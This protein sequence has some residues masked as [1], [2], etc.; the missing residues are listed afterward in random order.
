MTKFLNIS[1]DNTLGGNSPSDEV[2]SSQ[3]AIKEYVDNNGGSVSIDNKSI[4]ENASNELQTI[5]VINQNGLTQAVKLWTG[6]KAQFDLLT[7]DANTLYNI[8]D[9]ET[10]TN[11]ANTDL[12]NLSLTG[13]AVLDGKANTSL[14]NL[15]LVG[16]AILDGK[17]SKTGDTMSGELIAP[18]LTVK[19]QNITK[20]T[21]PA[22]NQYS[23]FTF[24]SNDTGGGWER[25]RLGIIELRTYTDGSNEIRIG[26]YK[27][28]TDSTT[29]SRIWA[30]IDSSGNK[31]CGFPDTTCVEGQWITATTTTIASGISGSSS[32]SNTFTIPTTIMPDDGYSYEI[33]VHAEGRTGTSSGNLCRINLGSTIMTSP[34]FVSCSQTRTSSYILGAGTAII[35]IGS[36]RKLTV[37]FEHANGTSTNVGIY[38]HAYRR[39]GTNS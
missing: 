8:T 28:E 14:S 20:G 4:T 3:K 5:G 33:L 22:S 27:N 19:N 1:I 13:Q 11:F 7:P 2:V 35:P 25:A 32:Y 9:D 36:D 26:A 16:Q 31:S 29:D 39:I 21:S 18:S 34:T 17:V 38:L 23:Q 15:S 10:P 12:S 37:D 6:T 30:K 24:K